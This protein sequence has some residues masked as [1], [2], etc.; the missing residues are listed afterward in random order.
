MASASFKM[1]VQADYYHVLFMSKINFNCFGKKYF[2]RSKEIIEPFKISIMKN[3]SK[4]IA[5]AAAG[6]AAGGALG[7]LFAPDKGSET[8]VK[9]DKQAKKLVK[10]FHSKCTKEQ[11]IMVKEKLEKHKERLENHIQ[12]I[13]TKIEA[14]ETEA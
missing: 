12:K 6:V 9:F 13:N 4:V 3:S 11:L 10:L 2:C 8:R 5:A 1:I 7:V 14:R